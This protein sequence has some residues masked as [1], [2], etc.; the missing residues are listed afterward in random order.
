M[1][2][3]ETPVLAVVVACSYRSPHLP[4]PRHPER[5]EWTT[6]LAVAVAVA[7]AVALAL[8][9]AL[10][11]AF[12]VVIPSLSEESAFL[13]FFV[14]PGN[15][16]PRS[17]QSQA[18]AARSIPARGKAPRNNRSKIEGRRPDLFCDL[19]R[20]LDHTHH[21][22]SFI[23]MLAICA[24]ARFRCGIFNPLQL[25]LLC[26]N[27]SETRYEQNMETV[28]RNIASFGGYCSHMLPPFL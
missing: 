22:K 27:N 24:M 13:P 21:M 26:F 7:V 28:C 12:L 23:P 5:S 25:D 9:L 10:A 1:R 2:S 16:S 6:V 20:T 11:L 3:G 14:R 18:P 4:N 17:A 19:A 15:D 8:A